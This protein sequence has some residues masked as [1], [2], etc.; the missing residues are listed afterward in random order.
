MCLSNPGMVAC[1]EFYG[2]GRYTEISFN[3]K[4]NANTKKKKKT[5]RFLNTIGN[6]PALG[7]AHP[8]PVPTLNLTAAPSERLTHLEA[9]V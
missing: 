7:W 6:P 8:F 4:E 1:A 9:I 2:S 5:P 3:D